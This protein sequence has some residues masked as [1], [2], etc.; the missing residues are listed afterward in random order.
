MFQTATAEAAKPQ[1]QQAQCNRGLTAAAGACTMATKLDRTGGQ[2]T[3]TDIRGTPPHRQLQL[4]GG[5]HGGILGAVGSER[6]SQNC[7][8][9]W[10]QVQHAHSGHTDNHP[11][12]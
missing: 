11:A 1:P 6:A 7:A 3:Q 2:Q 10:E 5:R 4:H 9:F 12:H 8:I